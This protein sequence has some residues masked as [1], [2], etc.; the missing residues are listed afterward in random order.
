MFTGGDG[1]RPATRGSEV[2]TGGGT[3]GGRRTH[4]L[5][6]GIAHAWG[7]TPRHPLLLAAVAVAV[8][9]GA[10]GAGFSATGTL[11]SSATKK[12]SDSHVAGATPTSPAA[13]SSPASTDGAASSDSAGPGVVEC[14]MMPAVPGVTGQRTGSSAAT[15]LGSATHLFTRTTAD[16]V[17]IRAYSLSLIGPCTC[18]PIPAGSLSSRSSSG[19]ASWGTQGQGAGSSVTPAVSVELSDDTAVGQGVLVDTPNTEATTTDSDPEPLAATSGAF[20]VVEGTPVWWVAVSVGSKVASVQVAFADGS[21][22]QMSPVDGVAILAHRIDPSM[23]PT[24]NGLYEVIATLQ[25][26]D[27]SGAVIDTMTFPEPSPTPTPAPGAPPEPVPGSTSS[28]SSASP[29]SGEL[30]RLRL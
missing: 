18:G 3:A 1:R 24:G 14:P 6:A 21:T 12:I 20:G 29:N 25:L 15:S 9:A 26:F 5:L 19:S 16:G 30:H 4:H 10:T 17:T 23:A 11:S 8:A 27:G 13:P 7:R 2:F 22:D 28:T